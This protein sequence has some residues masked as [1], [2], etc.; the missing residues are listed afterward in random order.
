MKTMKCT[1]VV[2]RYEEDN[3]LVIPCLNALFKQKKIYAEILFLDQKD[4]QIIKNFCKKLKNKKITVKY[5]KILPKSLSFARNFGIK[6]AKNDSIIFTD[7]DAI[8]N[9]NWAYQL[10]RKFNKRLKIGIVGGKSLP[11]WLLG[12]KWF[13]NSEIIKEMYSIIDLGE[14]SIN[15]KKII[16]VNFGINKRIL[17]NE[18]YFNEEL[19]RRPGTLLGGEET[20]LCKRCLEKGINI[21]YNPKAIVKHQVQEERYKWKWICKRFFYAGF[22][23]GMQGGMPKAYSNKR[24]IYDYII[25]FLMLPPYIMGIFKA[26]LLNI[27]DNRQNG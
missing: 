3:K 23:R 16:G 11:E 12:K 20:D 17:Q 15:V 21:I 27:M 1:I 10:C 8:P 6:L 25:M 19:G 14:K 2:T 22:G 4:D 7:A 24:N 26:K 18:C 13:C 9:E 5:I